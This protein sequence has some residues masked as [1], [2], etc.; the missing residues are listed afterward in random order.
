MAGLGLGAG[1]DLAQLQALGLGGGLGGASPG[2]FPAA[3]APMAHAG[4]SGSELPIG[5]TLVGTVKAWM[6]EKGFGFVTPSGG[7]PD[8]FVHR[9]QLTDGQSLVQGSAVTFECRFN[10][11]RS[12][13]E[14]TTCSGATTGGAGGAGGAPAAGGGGGAAG[15]SSFA[16]KGQGLGQD[17]LF[18]AGM[19]M[20]IS[21]EQV[22]DLFS[23]YGIVT[24]CKLLPDQPGRSDKAALVR[25]ADEN[26]AKWMVD[27]MNGNV[28]VGMS[29]PLTVRYAGDRPGG[30]G[31]GFGGF[32]KAPTAPAADHRFTPYGGPGLAAAPPVA[33]QAPPQSSEASLAAALAQLMPALQPALQSLQA[34]SV[35]SHAPP[36]ALGGGLGAAGDPTAAALRSLGGLIG[37]D[38]AGLTNGLLGLATS[39]ATQLLA[40]ATSPGLS[41]DGLLAGLAA[42]GGMPGAAPLGQTQNPGAVGGPSFFPPA[43]VGGPSPWLEAADATTGRTYYY[44]SVTRETRW[45]KPAEMG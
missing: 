33:S 38:S 25:F 34:A 1:F 12:K 11:Q 24:Q 14:A 41:L 26:Q 20:D 44:H 17:N 23:Q 19:P 32:G 28:P 9:N 2:G 5:Q 6:D 30:K 15:L 4:P 35:Q 13:Y 27:N 37:L 16:G 36:A 42:P 8:V 21:E 43:G 3:T 29:G 22:R 18:V 40:G 39:A 45:E 31:F 7:G 10:V